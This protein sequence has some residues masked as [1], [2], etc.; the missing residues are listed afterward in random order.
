MQGDTE[1]D[2]QTNMDSEI[3][4]L[5]VLIAPVMAPLENEVPYSLNA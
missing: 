4:L 5:E 2:Y 1:T 3:E